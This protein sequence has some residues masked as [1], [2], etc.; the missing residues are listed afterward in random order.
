MNWFSI[1]AE[2]LR[3]TGVPKSFPKHSESTFLFPLFPAPGHRGP[4]ALVSEVFEQ[5][6][7]GHI[8]QVRFLPSLLFRAATWWSHLGIAP[9]FL[10]Q[11]PVER[12]D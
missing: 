7:G 12:W 5:H 10:R 9:S 3:R 1:V 11:F 4:V 8:L 2:D 6:L